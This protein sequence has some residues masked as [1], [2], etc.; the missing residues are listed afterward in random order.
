MHI[1]LI[2]G[3]KK[4]CIQISFLRH[5][6]HICTY[7]L[8]IYNYRDS[9]HCL[10]GWDGVNCYFSFISLKRSLSGRVDFN[11]IVFNI[12]FISNN[13]KDTLLS[14]LLEARLGMR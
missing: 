2:Q 1:Y 13:N 12:L 7:I 10:E 3:K 11:Q 4:I 5:L 9:G 14:E 6:S 8:T